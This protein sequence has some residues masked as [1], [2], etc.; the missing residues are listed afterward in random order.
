M[1]D[2][3]T[4]NIRDLEACLGVS[5]QYIGRL[6]SE[7]VLTKSG[8]GVYP[9]V[10]NIRAYVDNLRDKQKTVTATDGSTKLNAANELAKLRESQRELVDIKIKVQLGQLVRTDQA[11][12]VYGTAVSQCKSRLQSLPN[13]LASQLVGLNVGDVHSILT[14]S[15]DESLNLLDTHEPLVD[16]DLLALI[17]QSEVDVLDGENDVE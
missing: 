12:R 9:L 4:V 17:E 5:E 6:V 13:K 10:T 2:D 1:L 8:R 3:L 11:E 16:A 15:I 14:V 7:G